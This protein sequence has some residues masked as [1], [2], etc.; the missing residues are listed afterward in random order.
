M[1]MG[2]YCIPTCCVCVFYQLFWISSFLSN[3]SNEFEKTLRYLKLFAI[4]LAGRGELL[5][6]YFIFSF[7]PTLCL[8]DLKKVVILHMS[9]WRMHHIYLIHGGG[10][11]SV[12]IL[13]SA[14]YTYFIKQ[15]YYY[16]SYSRSLMF[17]CS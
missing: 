10:Y 15:S 6:C 8:E 4:Q 2:N 17:L 12:L 5:H 1:I 7:N 16:Q 14:C 13:L 3:C 9:S 11:L